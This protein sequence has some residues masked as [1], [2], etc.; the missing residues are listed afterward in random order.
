MSRSENKHDVIA[1]MQEEEWTIKEIQK[2]EV[3]E[4]I[5]NGSRKQ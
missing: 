4:I 2:K 3:K 1:R 5:Q